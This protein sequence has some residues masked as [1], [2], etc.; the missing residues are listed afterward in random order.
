VVRRWF[1][2]LARR[3]GFLFEEVNLVRVSALAPQLIDGSIA[4]RGRD[5]C[6]GIVRQAVARPPLQS[7]REGILDRFFSEVYVA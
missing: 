5:P 6:G 4:R 1:R 7:Y 3:L 2:A